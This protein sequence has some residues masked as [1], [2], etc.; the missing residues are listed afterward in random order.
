MLRAALLLTLIAGTADAQCRTAATGAGCVAV[1]GARTGPR[2]L[3]PPPIEIGARMER[4]RY[5]ILHETAWYGL[6][7]AT[8]TWVY[9]RVEDDLYR[10][11]W[12]TLEVLE[13]VTDQMRRPWPEPQTGTAPGS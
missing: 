1:P 10:V 8:G 6:P 13:R 4:G 2:E 11:D 7:R 9:M 3:G 12:R 5:E